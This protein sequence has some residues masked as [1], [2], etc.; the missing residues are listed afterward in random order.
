[1][2]ARPPRPP[3]RWMGPGGR[4][5]G[6]ANRRRRA[7][8]RGPAVRC[9]DAG[10]CHGGQRRRARRSHRRLPGRGRHSDCRRRHAAWP[11]TA[12][13]ACSRRGAS[14]PPGPWRATWRACFRRRSHSCA[15]NGRDDRGPQPASRLDRG[16]PS[17]DP[18]NLARPCVPARPG[19]EVIARRQGECLRSRRRRRG[20]D[21]RSPPA[22]SAS[23]S[24]PST[25]G[26]ASATRGSRAPIARAL[27]H[28]SGRGVGRGRGASSSRSST[29]RVRSS[30]SSRPAGRPADPCAPQGRYRPR[31]PGRRPGR[32]RRARR[33][34]RAQATGSSWQGR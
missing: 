5:Q 24:R 9:R 26:C 17:R 10:P 14:A 30:C 4:A 25:R 6:R 28:R 13:P 3:R 18:L 1:M 15:A 22:S 16:R 7:R 32:C 19:S 2:G 11:R 12:R 33:A 31:A 8:W 29:T 21:A 34:D 27:G 23:R 20:A